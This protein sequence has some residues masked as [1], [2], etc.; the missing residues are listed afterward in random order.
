MQLKVTIWQ[1][2]ENT[3][4]SILRKNFQQ[5][6]TLTFKFEMTEYGASYPQGEKL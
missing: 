5:I 4:L 2:T 1:G 3:Y 6:K